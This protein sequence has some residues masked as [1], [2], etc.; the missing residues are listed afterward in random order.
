MAIAKRAALGVPSV[1]KSPNKRV[2]SGVR[3]LDCSFCRLTALKLKADAYL[4]QSATVIRPVV[5]RISL[6]AC[7]I[8]FQRIFL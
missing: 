3:G 2:A 1:G 8:P 5:H 6:C 4:T 7:S